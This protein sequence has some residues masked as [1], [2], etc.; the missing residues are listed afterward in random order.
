M[1]AFVVRRG[2]RAAGADGSRGDPEPQHERAV[3]SHHGVVLQLPNGLRHSVSAYRGE[4]VHHDLRDGAEP[5]G[6][7]WLDCHPEQWGVHNR[8]CDGSNGDARMVLEQVR[9]DHQGRP[10]L[11][12]VALKGDHDQHIRLLDQFGSHKADS[13]KTP[14]PLHPF[15]AA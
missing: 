5:I 11:A 1:Q 6:Y 13:V 9:L 12:V 15:R 2:G 10:R 3:N 14:G 7:G 8:A 4:F